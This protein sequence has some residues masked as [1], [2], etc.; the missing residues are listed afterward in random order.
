MKLLKP[1][2]IP[3]LTPLWP[4]GETC[5]CDYC[6]AEWQIETTND[7]ISVRS[8]SGPYGGRTIT[9]TCP[10]CGKQCRYEDKREANG[11]KN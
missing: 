4:I 2:K 10:T 5:R 1:G 6:G 9:S 7:Y 8:A 3:A 11:A